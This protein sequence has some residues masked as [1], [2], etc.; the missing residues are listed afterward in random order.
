MPD[1]LHKVGIKSASLNEVYAALTTVEGLSAWW[2]TRTQGEPPGRSNVGGVQLT[3]K[4]TER[5]SADG[6]QPSPRRAISTTEPR[7]L[8]RT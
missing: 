8:R 7:T 3:P 1:I 5:T 2:T 4:G 6:A